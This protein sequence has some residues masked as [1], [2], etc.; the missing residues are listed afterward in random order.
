L[1]FDY[2]NV[3]VI[4]ERC[5]LELTLTCFD[6]FGFGKIGVID[7]AA[8]RH[9]FGEVTLRKHPDHRDP[10]GALLSFLGNARDPTKQETPNQ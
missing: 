8:N 1:S 5:D 10:M 2:D 9:H 6:L 7:F 4:P 3:R